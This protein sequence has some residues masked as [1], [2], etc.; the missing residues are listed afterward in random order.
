LKRELFVGIDVKRELQHVGAVVGEHLLE[1]V[2]VVVTSGPDRTRHHFVHTLHQD[3]L[4]MRPVEDRHLPLGRRVLV[5]APEKIVCGLLL[6]RHLAAGD[7]TALWI[8][9][10]Q[11]VV[12]RAILAG[13]VAALQHDQQGTLP[14]RVH[15][16]L[17]IVQLLIMGL[18]LGEC[19]LMGLVLVRESG[20]DRFQIDL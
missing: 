17:Q 5:I 3:I 8:H 11:H 16:V 9:G 12:D 7:R 4:I 2:D 14:F 19:V 18:D 13:S 6:G 10:T 1:G 15:Q 20:V